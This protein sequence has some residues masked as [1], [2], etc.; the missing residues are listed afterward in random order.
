[1]GL[2]TWIVVAVVVLAV[3]GLGAGVFF[4]GLIRG[5][6]I[7]GENPAVQNATQEAGEFVGDRVEISS[8]DV[9]IITTNQATYSVG[10]PVIITVRNNGDSMM[11]F[12]DSALGLEIEN[13]DTGQKYSIPAAQAITELEPGRS[14]AITWN[15]DDAAT[16]DYVA[17]VHTTP[18]NEGI[19]AQVGFEIR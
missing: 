18:P 19:S 5:A 9:L 17:T 13:V 15:T 14:K 8:N 6:Q 11:E 12:S 7:V 16:G 2:L 10:D 1:M 4:S 3:I